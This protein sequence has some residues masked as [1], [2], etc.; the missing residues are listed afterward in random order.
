MVNFDD[1]TCRQ[2]F[3]QNVVYLHREFHI[4]G[5]RFDHTHTIVHS[6]HQTG[7]VTVPGSGGGWDFLAGL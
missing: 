1:P 2:F 3:E 7:F 4:D 6:H 5:F